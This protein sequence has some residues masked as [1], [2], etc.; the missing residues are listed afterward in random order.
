[1]WPLASA[2]IDIAFHRRGPEDLPAS[3]FL[4]ALLFPFYLVTGFGILSVGASTDGAGVLFFIAEACAYI[5]FFWLILSLAGKPA[6]FRQTAS[7]VLGTT[8]W[9]NLLAM[10]LL[11]WHDASTTG[12]AE[13]S[14]PLFGYLALVLWSIDISGY[15]LSRA[16]EQ[17]YMVGVLIVILYFMTSLSL[18]SAFSVT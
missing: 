2:F 10:P 12:E 14:V 18:A 11:A 13:T 1:M 3:G 7:A 8:I 6:R 9:L 5:G 15:I 17:P 16:L 4:V